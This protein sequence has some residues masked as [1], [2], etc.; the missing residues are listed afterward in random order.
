MQQVVVGPAS[1]ESFSFDA[2]FGGFILPKQVEGHAIE[3]REI[4][5]RVLLAFTVKVFSE[6]DIKGPM[7]LVFNPAVLPDRPIQP[8]GIGLEA[9]DVVADFSLGL[10]RDLVAALTLDTYQPL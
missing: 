7:Q 6:A 4:S 5:G 3:Q 9:G 10:V 1:F 8:P 2:E